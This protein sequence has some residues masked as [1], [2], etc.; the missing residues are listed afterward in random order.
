MPAQA[1]SPR[2]SLDATPHS[3]K[4]VVTVHNPQSDTSSATVVETVAVRRTPQYS[5]VMLTPEAL[6]ALHGEIS[7]PAGDSPSDARVPVTSD[8]VHATADVADGKITF[9]VQFAPGTLDR[10]KTRAVILLDTDQNASTG[11]R[12]NNG[13]GVDYSIEIVSSQATIS[14]ANAASCAA[15]RGCYDVLRSEPVTFLPDAIQVSVSLA[16][17]GGT[18]GRMTFTVHSYVTILV[19]RTLT[20]ISFD[21]MP[22]EFLPPGR[23]Q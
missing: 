1:G 11:I 14:M 4:A 22:D 6:P 13:M 21:S 12:Q 19:G 10:Q 20:P 23:I 3:R 7:D 8:L 17:L 9:A 15:R 5:D 18:D 16:T 2:Q